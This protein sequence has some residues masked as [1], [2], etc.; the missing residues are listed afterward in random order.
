MSDRT[1]QHLGNY[2]LLRL[3]GKGGFAEVYLGKH[4]HLATQAAIKVLLAH[5]GSPTDVEGFR[6]EAQTIARLIHPHIVR[7]L[8]FDVAQGVPFLVMEYAPHGSLRA[9]HPR[10]QP[11]P[12]SLML[13]YVQQIANALHYAH[14][15][16]LIHRDVKPDNMLLREDGSVILSDFGIVTIAHSTSSYQLTGRAGTPVYMAP[17][18][19]NGEPRPA[20]DQYALAVTVYEW[21]TG[22]LPFRGTALEVAMQHAMKHPPSLIEQVPTLPADV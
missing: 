19:M 16:K 15:R 18:Q 17:E 4:T 3:L 14:E 13:S 5:L 6:E 8:D 21:I 2:H 20:S 12:L 1:G 7:V 22:Q 11:I 9:Q 10:G